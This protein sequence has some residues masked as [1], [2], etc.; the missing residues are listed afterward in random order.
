MTPTLASSTQP[1][2][3]LAL[4]LALVG[5]SAASWT[6]ATPAA[7]QETPAQTVPAQT[8]P[9]QT[10]DGKA[11]AKR[12]STPAPIQGTDAGVDP[13]RIRPVKRRR[14]EGVYVVDEQGRRYRVMFPL[15]DRFYVEGQYAPVSQQPMFLQQGGSWAGRLGIK[16][17]FALSFTDE[18]IW[19]NLRHTFLDLTAFSVDRAFS[20]RGT[21]I[22][23]SY[24]RHDISSVVL[25]PSLGDMRLPAPFDLAMDYRIGRGT[26]TYTSDGGVDFKR[27]EV[28][29]VAFLLDFM[30]DPQYRHRLAIGPAGWYHAEP[31]A[32]WKNELAPLSALKL[33][34]GWQ[35]ADGRFWTL[36][37][38]TC[39]AAAHFQGGSEGDW[40]WRCRGE[41]NLEWL[42]VAINDQPISLPIEARID[43]PLGDT[44][45]ATAQVT[46]GLRL[47][48]NMD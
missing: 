32:I 45:N 7:A 30:R 46:V 36:N 39:G 34:Y 6:L 47:S 3:A 33:V 35:R 4:A 41:V 29:D 5:A 26:F 40:R 20:V 15:Y 21:L 1:R 23:A 18:S 16:S 37:H 48:F 28:A 27:L 43:I 44:A 8:V 22:D 2:R 24:L 25:I 19:W 14:R 42:L 10:V 13:R 9:A 12:G 17:A 31:G 11:D 38:A